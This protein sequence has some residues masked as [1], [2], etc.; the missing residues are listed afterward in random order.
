MAYVYRHIRSDKNEVFYIGVGLGDDK[1][2]SRAYSQKNRNF[3]WYSIVKNTS[4][5][6]EI[7]IDDLTDNEAFEKEI[8]FITIYGK[9][10]NGGTLC[11]IADGGQGGCLGEEVNKIRSQSL[12]GHKLSDETKDKIRR[13]SKGRKASA[14]TKQKMSDTH[15][16]N[17]TGSWL[18]SKGHHNGRA[19]KVYQFDLSG[20]FI[21]EWEC[22]TYASS[23]LGINKSCISETIN[24][25]QKSAGGYLWTDNYNPS[26]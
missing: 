24:K 5:D 20:K 21:R 18:K 26:K 11:N 22:S 15:K 3:H 1:T 25:K 4:Y 16:K 13:A 9:K 2:Y 23:E 19:K 14:L 6:I 7:M 10:N 12:R 8:E 17:K